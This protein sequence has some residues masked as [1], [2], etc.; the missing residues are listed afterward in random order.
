MTQTGR[1]TNAAAS[2]GNDWSAVCY[3]GWAKS[4][5]WVKSHLHSA[6]RSKSWLYITKIWTFLKRANTHNT[7][8]C[9]NRIWSL[10]LCYFL[11][12]FL[13]FC[14]TERSQCPQTPDN[15]SAAFAIHTMTAIICEPLDCE[16]HSQFIMKNHSECWLL[17]LPYFG[18]KSLQFA[19]LWLSSR[20]GWK[21]EKK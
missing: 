21:K 2:Q 17:E 3:S 10:I 18:V 16:R 7:S 14:K 15:M 8:L 11:I 5:S 13:S 4:S 1:L 9:L 20:H 19:T 6:N 12:S